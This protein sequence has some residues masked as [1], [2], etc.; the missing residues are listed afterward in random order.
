MASVYVSIGQAGHVSNGAQPV[1]SGPVATE[2]ITSSGTNA[3]GS[4]VASQ[5]SVAKIN[6]ETAIYVTSG[7]A[8]ST[9]AGQYLAAGETGWI[10]MRAGDKINVIDV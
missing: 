3:E 4:L 2:V 6:C 9:S 8:A 5:G 7:A 10:G 1:F